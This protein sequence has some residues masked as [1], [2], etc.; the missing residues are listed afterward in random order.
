LLAVMHAVE[1]PE[2]SYVLKSVNPVAHKVG[3]E[4]IDRQGPIGRN[5]A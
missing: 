1:G 5:P 3:D 2:K 4:E